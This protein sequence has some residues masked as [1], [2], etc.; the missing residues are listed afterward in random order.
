MHI[1][2]ANT[3]D[4]PGIMRVWESSVL[5]THDFL[6][7]S[8]FELFKR[9]IPEQFL[10]ALDLYVIGQDQIAGVLGVSGEN[11]EML[12]IDAAA[13]AKASDSNW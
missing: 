1:R 5:A 8:D 10:P 11:L 2:K 3:G 4:Y 6:Q 13:R 12:F 9:I 7:G